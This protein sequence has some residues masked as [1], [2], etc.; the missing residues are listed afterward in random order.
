MPKYVIKREVPGIGQLSAREQQ[1][2]A[3]KTCRV[4]DEL[5]PE[6]QWQHSYISEDATHCIYIAASEEIIHEHAERSELPVTKI[7][8]VKT[9][10]DPTTAEE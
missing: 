2:A 6:I 1:A 10:L 7:T 8:E 9:M 3:M 4:L 5:G